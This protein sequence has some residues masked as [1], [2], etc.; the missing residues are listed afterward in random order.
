MI[1]LPGEPNWCFIPPGWLPIGIKPSQVGI[2]A[3][4]NVDEKFNAFINAAAK[5]KSAGKRSFKFKGKRYPEL[6]D[7][8]VTKSGRVKTKQDELGYKMKKAA[9][10]A[11]SK[12]KKALVREAK[13]E[14]LISLYADGVINEAQLRQMYQKLVS[15]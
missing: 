15:E 3:E 10:N 1:Y 11:L 6:L 7:A 2:L 9:S 12:V 14:Q 8:E 5:A 13:E 4:G